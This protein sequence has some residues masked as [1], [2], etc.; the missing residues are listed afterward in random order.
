[1]QTPTIQPES[2]LTRRSYRALPLG[3]ILWFLAVVAAGCGG[4]SGA[5]PPKAGAAGAP[6]SP[7]VEAYA[8]CLRSHGVPM[9]PD[10][11]SKGQVSPGSIDLNSP[12]FGKAQEFCRSLAPRGQAFGGSGS[13]TP[14]QQAQFLRFARC[15]RAHGVPKFPD[16]T[17]SGLSPS[18]LDPNSPRFQAAQ[19]V[20]RSLLANRG[21]GSF[22]TTGGSVKP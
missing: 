16:P 8:K 6:G 13:L 3:A 14:Q 4:G 17:R 10:P 12:Q 9:F 1:M 20:C 18:G 5:A 15:M 7:G 11:N 21:R 19:T 22:Q 2:H